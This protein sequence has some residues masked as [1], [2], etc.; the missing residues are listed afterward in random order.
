MLTAKPKKPQK[1]KRKIKR[2]PIV[3]NHAWY[4]TPRLFLVIGSIACMF[5]LFSTTYLFYQQWKYSFAVVPSS[6][7]SKEF[8]PPTLVGLPSLNVYVPIETGTIHNGIWSVSNKAVSHL[9]QSASPGQSGNIVLYGHNTPNMLGTLPRIQ[10]GDPIH[11]TT[12]DG[13]L[14]NYIVES[15]ST[16]LPTDI[17]V[18]MP[19]ETEQLTLYTCTGL[20]DSKRFIVKAVPATSL[21][22]L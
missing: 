22:D 2:L 7:A 17:G 16:V 6:T 10:I 13:K 14:H 20:F 12:H 19:T 4:K 15:I 9:Q 3:Q 21:T 18:V 8:S 11:I 5:F 1:S